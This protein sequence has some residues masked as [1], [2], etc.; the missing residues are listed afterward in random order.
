MSIVRLRTLTG[1]SIIG[2]GNYKDLTI[3]NLLDTAQHKELLN[4]YYF[5]RNIDFHEDII[6]QLKIDQVYRIDKKNSTEEERFKRDYYGYIGKCLTLIIEEQNEKNSKNNIIRMTNAR[7]MKFD[8]KKNIEHRV[9]AISSK[10]YLK[11]KNQSS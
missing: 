7:R 9:N 1:K 3:Q 5:L 6:K 8:K 11:Y 10:G 4:M 2:F